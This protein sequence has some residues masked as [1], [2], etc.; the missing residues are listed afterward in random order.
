MTGFGFV[1]TFRVLNPGPSPAVYK[2]NRQQMKKILTIL[3]LGFGMQAA[4][5]QD[6]TAMKQPGKQRKEGRHYG[7]GMQHPR[8]MMGVEL[9]EAQKMKMAELRKKHKEE[10]M[11]ILTPEQR[12]QMENQ[13][14]K[15]MQQRH[16]QREQRQ[17]QMKQQ[18]NLT[19]AQSAQ[20]AQLRQEHQEQVKLIKANDKL[21]EAEKRK[22]LKALAGEHRTKVKT[23]LTPEQQEVMKRVRHPK[24]S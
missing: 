21:A 6:S 7:M 10:M 8:Q 24:K 2:R 20:I 22:Q 9:T 23:L 12:Q 4:M 3:V 17:E 16:D 15:R 19:E 18:L 11:A 1:L 5:A 14:Q 13:Q